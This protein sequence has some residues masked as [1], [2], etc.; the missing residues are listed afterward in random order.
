[1]DRPTAPLFSSEDAHNIYQTLNVCR[2][3]GE[4]ADVLNKVVNQKFDVSYR[5][6]R[7]QA[8]SM[9][10]GREPAKYFRLVSKPFPMEQP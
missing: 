6:E 7:N 8:W 4:L 2:T 1:M 9:R 5:T 3:N 10:P